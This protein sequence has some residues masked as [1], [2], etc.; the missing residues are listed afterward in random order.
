M[1]YCRNRNLLNGA[2]GSEVI[3]HIAMQQCTSGSDGIVSDMAD[4]GHQSIPVRSE[5]MEDAWR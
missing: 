5:P 2:F 3:G 1:V 4:C